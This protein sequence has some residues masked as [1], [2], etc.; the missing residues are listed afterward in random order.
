M[1][2][3]H[4][5]S[6][7]ISTTALLVQKIS[8]WI[9]LISLDFSILT[10]YYWCIFCSCLSK[11]TILCIK[12]YFF[13]NYWYLSQSISCVMTQ[14]NVHIYLSCTFYKV[15]VLGLVVGDV[16]CVSKNLK[17]GNILRIWRPSR[18]FF[19]YDRDRFM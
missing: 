7:S 16:V 15:H 19:E 8:Y 17:K 5:G 2:L 12:Y 3:D 6:N 10:S 18:C 1:S 4:E 13:T 9:T 14:S 11:K